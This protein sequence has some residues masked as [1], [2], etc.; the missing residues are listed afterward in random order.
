MKRK[1][2]DLSSSVRERL[3]AQAKEAGR[4]FGEL[5][6]YFAMERFL[7]RLGQSQYR[8]SLILKGALMFTVWKTP[9]SRATRDIDFLGRMDNSL[10]SLLP[11]IKELCIMKVEPDGI[12]FNPESIEADRIKEDAVYEGIRFRFTAHLGHA[13]VPMQ[14][15]I[16]FGDPVIPGPV[17]V[18]YPVLLDMPSPHLKGYP[19]ETIIS[20]KVEA[21]VKL[22]ILNSRMKDFYDLSILANQSD[23]DGRTLSRAIHETFTNR[24]TEMTIEPEALSEGFASDPGKNR[25]WKAF[26]KRSRLESAPK[27]LR[28]VLSTLR[29]FLVP[30]LEC[31]A[32]EEHCNFLWR[33]P[34]PWKAVP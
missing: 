33:P 2:K 7:Y 16:G 10:E 20:E 32:R 9:R 12:L 28:E 34:G 21:M 19:P 24:K 30:I 25:Q 5:L 23:F 6:Q 8:D 22:G 31:C 11:V 29:S 17:K 27:E 15:D 26:L 18:V 1:I 14:I 4:P 13:R 3:Y